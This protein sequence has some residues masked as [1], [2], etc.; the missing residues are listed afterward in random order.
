[1]SAIAR[2]D[3]GPRGFYKAATPPGRDR[4]TDEPAPDERYA[5]DQ[6]DEG[7]DTA[8]GGDRVDTPEGEPPP[9]E[10][11]G[12]DPQTLMWDPF[13]IVEQL[14]YRD[15]PSQLTYAT[16]KAM[17]WRVPV[18]RAVIQTRLNQ[19]GAFCTPQRDRYHLGYRIRTRDSEHEPTPA[20]KKW[21]KQMESVLQRT[22]VTENPRGRDSFEMFIRK[23][24]LDSLVYDQLCFEVVPDKKGRPCEWYAVDAATVRLAD[25][26]SVYLHQDI[27]K[28]VKYVQIYDGMII[29]EYTQNELAFCV[30]NP[31]TDIRLY[32]YG[33]SELEMMVDAVTSFLY[34]W[35]YNR[36]FFSQGSSAK[37]LINLKG[38]IPEKQLKAFRR[39]WYTMISGVENC[40]AGSTQLWT[41]DGATSIGDFLG[42]DQEKETRLW[43]GESWRSALVYRTKEPK[44]L[45]RTTLANG[46]M[47]ETSPDHK[48][49]ILG[50]D[51]LPTWKEQKELQ[52]GDYVF[53]NKISVSSGKAPPVYNGREITPELAEILGWMT[54]DGYIS[55][56]GRGHSKQNLLQLFY[57][58][59]E[60][61]I[62]DMHHRTLES[63]G[64]KAEK[65]EKHLSDEEADAICERYGFRTVSQTQY[66]MDLFDVNFLDWLL[67]LGF[68][69]SKKSDG[70]KSIPG[71][72]FVLPE[73]FKAAF[74]RGL[75]SADGNNAKRRSPQ[76][77]IANSRVRDQVKLMLLSLG[78]RTN[79]SEGRSKL[80]IKGTSRTYVDGKSHLTV[81]D[82]DRFFDVIGFLQEHKQPK[83]LVKVNESNKH[84]RVPEIT[85]LRFLRE[86]RAANDVSGKTLL[87]AR[88][89]M[90]LNS[91]L[92]GQ[93]RCGLNRLL[94]FMKASRVQIPEWLYG[95]YFEPVVD[96]ET[97][98]DMAPMFDVQ[99]YDDAHAFSG[100][101]LV[102]H[103]SW[104][105]PILN[106]E[107]VQWLNMQN[108][109]RE[110]E[111]SAYMDFI[112]KILCSI[113]SID[114]IEV[115]FQYGNQ[116]QKSSLNSQSNREK[117][118][119]SKERGLRPLIRFLSGIINRHIIWPIN[120]SF[121]FEFVGLDSMTRE[122][123]TDVN[124]KRV[125]N[126]RTIDEIRAEDDYPPLPDGKG[127]MLMNPTWV[128]Y[129]SQKDQMAQQGA[130]GMPGQS[131]MGQG[132][133]PPGQEQDQQG[134][135]PFDEQQM[136]QQLDQGAQQQQQGPGEQQPPEQPQP[137]QPMAK[138]YGP[139]RIVV[140][141]D[142]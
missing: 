89:R 30:R 83:P 69:P 4:E 106:A 90:D 54:G 20:D 141:M 58:E 38:A 60:L 100:N 77:T 55:Y 6:A 136:A 33:T 17:A 68:T 107:D 48:F 34:A 130:G 50:P 64:L 104:R 47:V 103:N 124:V 113:Y 15:R 85:Y 82:K 42:N 87:T 97:T 133:L 102:L 37:G 93:D 132:Q 74:L 22:G 94:R 76:V 32:G 101:G 119:E 139:R 118:T 57:N 24:M 7:P 88:E 53:V 73:S 78:I 109:N 35:E 49:R 80:V 84:S 3:Y 8:P 31:S 12:K 121:E 91:I 71:F 19:L 122:Q 70:G 23:V 116:G 120:E 63:Y 25:S 95:Y 99:V 61:G 108:S 56:N 142:L 5:D 59:K 67:S 40:V 140:D 86:V 126:F 105:T 98:P 137:G 112:I 39:H 46:I 128:Q 110:M 79:L 2:Y 81:K 72:L 138:A 134:E 114:P 111:F 10:P 96:L 9:D 65:R 129:A 29:T 45:T 123:W 11:S 43:T 18:V 44:Q 117:I 26:A 27:D 125:A 13:A 62:R 28:A 16:L 66:R 14:G 1:M 92:S 52:I 41:I 135:Q 115:N 127:E 75:F 51:G 131:G 21:I 36:R